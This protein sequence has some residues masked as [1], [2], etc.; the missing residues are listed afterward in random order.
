MIGNPNM[1]NIWNFE[2][3]FGVFNIKLTI[4]SALLLGFSIFSEFQL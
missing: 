3:S 1:Y 2:G 4:V